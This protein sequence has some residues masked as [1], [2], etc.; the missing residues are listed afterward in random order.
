MK[1]GCGFG[2][3]AERR[4]GQKPVAGTGMDHLPSVNDGRWMFRSSSSAL[5]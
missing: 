2:E 4:M 1:L 3:D 5:L